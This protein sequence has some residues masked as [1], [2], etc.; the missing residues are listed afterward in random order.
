V[1]SLA[2]VAQSETF[3]TKR[4]KSHERNLGGKAFVYLR[5]L[6]GWCPVWHGVVDSPGGIQ[7]EY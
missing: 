5:A 1:N 6:R 3:P 4:T 2:V 7:I